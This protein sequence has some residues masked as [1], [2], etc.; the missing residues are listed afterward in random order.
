[1]PKVQKRALELAKEYFEKKNGKEKKRSKYRS[2]KTVVD[3]HEFDS[4]KEAKRYG[5][6]KI[7]EKAG[8]IS[9]LNLQPSIPLKYEGVLICTY[10]AD[11]SYFDNAIGSP[12]VEDV[13]GFKTP[14]YRLKKKMVAAFHGILVREV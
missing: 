14:V 8:L 5:E 12:V 6:L 3:G 1:M 9:N 13:K 11:F 7:L 2:L 10:R 4:I